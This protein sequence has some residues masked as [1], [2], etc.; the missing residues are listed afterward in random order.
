MATLTPRTW[1]LLGVGLMLTSVTMAV[2]S[3]GSMLNT[4]EGMHRVVVPAG[5]VET[6]HTITLPPGTSTLYA[7]QRAIVDGKSYEAGSDFTYRCN[8][9][10]K[11]R[12]VTFAK[13]SGKITYSTGD[14]AGADAWDI[15]VVESGDYVL[16]CQ[17]ER[18]LVMALG[19]GVGSAMVV[20]IVGLVPFT[21]G[22]VFIVVV[23]LKRRKQLRAG[24]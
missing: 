14:Y 16:V 9:D 20:A 1:Y 17:S 5:N 7:E 11:T 21:I 3:F 24:V 12:K 10:E 4:I 23:F 15:D 6:R 18:E 8:V 2:V 13:A 22:L 19:R